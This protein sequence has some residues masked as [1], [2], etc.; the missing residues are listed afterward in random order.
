MLA[1]IPGAQ[2]ERKK[3]SIAVHYRRVEKGRVQVVEEAVDQVLA[4]QTGLRKGMGK[5]VF[6]L[7]PEIDW[8]KGKAL[9]WLMDALDLDHPD[10]LPFYIGDD[11]TDE[12]AFRVLQAGGIGVVVKDDDAGESPRRSTARYALDDCREV[13]K[14]LEALT[15]TLQGESP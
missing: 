2:I 14:F 4:D 10:V 6:E 9:C 15:E 13:Q 1:N 8:H 3:F 11:V 7:Q 5:K 12:D